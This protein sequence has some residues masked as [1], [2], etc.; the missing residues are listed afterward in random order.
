MLQEG[1][2]YGQP[3]KP[4]TMQLAFVQLNAIFR[5][6]AEKGYEVSIFLFSYWAQRRYVY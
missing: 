3:A 6:F 4:S 1:G 5:F 2:R